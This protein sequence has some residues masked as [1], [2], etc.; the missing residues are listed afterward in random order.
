MITIRKLSIIFVVVLVMFSPFIS[1]AADEGRDVGSIP[2]PNQSIGADPGSFGNDST[3]ADQITDTDKKIDIFFRAQVIKVLK[4]EDSIQSDGSK[5]QQQNLLLKGLEGKFNNQIVEFT[6]I[7]NV[8]LPTDM[9]Y[10]AGDRVIVEASYDDQGNIIY[11]ITDYDRTPIIWMLFII[12]ALSLFIFGRMKGLR[13]IFA[14][15]GSFVVMMYLIVP[16][17]M[18]GTNALVISLAGSILILI[19]IIYI[20]EGWNKRAHIATL[21]IFTSLLITIILSYV[22]VRLAHLTGIGSEEA[23]LLA[24]SPGGFKFDMSGLLLSG[25]IVGTLGVL[26]DMV[27]A[28]VSAVEQ[29]H[30]TDRHMNAKDLY[31]KAYAIG[32]SHISSMTNTLFLA[33]A[34]AALPLLILFSQGQ[35]AQAGWQHVINSEEIATE[36]IRT[37]AGSIGLILS[38]PIS[39]WLAVKAYKNSR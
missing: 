35:A 8:T 13:A 30:F 19:I 4:A 1:Q 24:S 29:L 7:G 18:K 17:I 31:T 38:V 36:I 11:Y 20:S 33:Y 28:Q 32:R 12:F 25:I 34:G 2:A 15:I 22:F 27:I 9:K 23:A 6:G 5:I 16:Q 14:L 37:L 3:T 26:D 10:Q 39:T 21:S